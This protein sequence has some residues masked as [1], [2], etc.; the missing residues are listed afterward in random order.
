MVDPGNLVNADQTVLTTLVSV[1]PMYAY[2]DVDERTYLELAAITA[3]GSNSFFSA[4]QFPVLMRLANDEEFNTKGYVNFLD[5]RLNSTTGTVRMRGVFANPNGVFKSGLFA[6]IRLPIGAP[7][8]TLMIPAEALM[9][10]QG[11][12]Y[13]YVVKKEKDEKGEEVDKVEYRSVK[14]GQELQGMC[15]IKEGIKDGERVVVAGMQRVR[16]SAVVKAELREPPPP[17]PSP[18]TKILK[19]DRAAKVANPPSSTPAAPS[20]KDMPRLEKE[21]RGAGRGNR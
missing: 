3:Q 13:V 5:N 9:S 8:K 4:L 11:R 12:K 15:V 14:L 19:E 18:L 17:P 10:D 1:D 6:R 16:P 21:A 20:L 2:F 7:Y